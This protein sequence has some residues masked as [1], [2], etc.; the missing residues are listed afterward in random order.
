MEFMFTLM[1]D[2]LALYYV[3]SKTDFQR[4]QLI[5]VEVNICLT[6]EPLSNQ[7]ILICSIGPVK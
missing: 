2:R 6:H 7:Q 1:P 4:I 5:D 3:H